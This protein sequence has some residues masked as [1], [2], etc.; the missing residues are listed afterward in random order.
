M[1]FWLYKKE[2]DN[3]T[4]LRSIK[5][6]G[7]TGFL[8]DYLQ[9]KSSEDTPFSWSFENDSIIKQIA[10]ELDAAA[11]ELVFDILPKELSEVC[12]YRVTTIRGLS[13]FDETDMVLAYKILQQGT[14]SEASDVF[15]ES[16]TVTTPPSTRQ[17]V[18]AF[19]MSGGIAT[20]AYLWGKPKLDLGA[21]ICPPSD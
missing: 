15:K 17:V 20:G 12:L 11:H 6:S 9:S 21:A 5:L 18:E 16:F 8:A 2:E 1:A 13:E 7:K 4:R 10:P 3:Y 19:R 14:T